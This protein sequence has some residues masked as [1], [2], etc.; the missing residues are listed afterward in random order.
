MTHSETSPREPAPLADRVHREIVQL[1][2]LIAVAVVAFALTRAVA[3]SNHDT[4]LRD[5]ADWY[6]Q[7]QRQ[8]QVGDLDAAVAA[9]RRAAVKNPGARQY[10]LALARA[11]AG[12][13][14]DAEAR[15]TLVALRESSPEDA[16]VNIELA[17]LAAVRQ[18][19]TEAVRYYHNALYSPWSSAQT[20]AR[21]QVRLELA[22]FLIAHAQ[23]SPAISELLI[24]SVDTPDTAAAHVELARLFSEAGDLPHASDQFASAL[25]RE[26]ENGPALAGAGETAFR[27]GDYVAARRYLR[28]APADAAV[29]DMKNVAD[30]VVSSDP[31][32][33]RLPSTE[34][35]R[36]L[37][38]VFTYAGRR[39]EACVAAGG[40]AEADMSSLQREAASFK[41][42][43]KPPA[44]R[45]SDTLEAGADLSLRIVTAAARHCPPLTS[46]DRALD[47]IARSHGADAR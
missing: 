30:L 24:S 9:F 8:I 34:R 2:V 12:K 11:L 14:L 25:K 42:K 3:A 28:R 6:A 45:E 15:S 27:A 47:L 43:L 33:S 10:M 16:E 22:R 5:A 17:R 26:P 20:D 32:A 44:I 37:I 4:N 23:A 29:T 18:D 38:A 13:R 36:R 41:R 19:V 39:L 1:V 35:Q 7:G 21:R 31:L 46:M 40:T